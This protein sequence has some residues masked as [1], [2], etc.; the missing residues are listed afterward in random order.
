V[1]AGKRKTPEQVRRI[2]E[3]RRERKV[4]VRLRADGPERVAAID[5]AQQLQFLADQAPDP[6]TRSELNQIIG[7]LRRRVPA[8]SPYEQKRD[9]VVRRLE[10][11]EFGLSA[12][13]L[14]EDTGLSREDIRLVLG[15]LTSA[16]VDL[17]IPFERG[18]RLNGGRAGVTL[19]YRLRH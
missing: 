14:A 10:K 16:A 18:G 6:E 8:A 3:R 11:C 7:R 9:A 13:E 4:E 5:Y 15:E 17:V 2:S 19:Y 1:G 12:R